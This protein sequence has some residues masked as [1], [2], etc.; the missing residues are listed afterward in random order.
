MET[1]EAKGIEQFLHSVV[2]FLKLIHYQIDSL[3][4]GSVQASLAPEKSLMNHIGTFYAG[5]LFTLGEATG[6]VAMLSR[7][8]FRKYKIVVRGGRI[9]FHKPA[10][11]AA[12]A[13]CEF[14]EDKAADL[15]RQLMETGRGDI[16][17]DVIIFNEKDE[18]A[19]VMNMTYA[20]RNY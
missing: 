14:P 8:E 15:R 17:L 18:Q 13:V 6:G 5:A 11:T 2:P 3:A 7:E 16:A 1:L 9:T 4:P 12:R 20:A 10:K 19:T